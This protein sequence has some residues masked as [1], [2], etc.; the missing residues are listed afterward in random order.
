MV[1]K[2][3]LFTSIALC[4]ILSIK[5]QT[6][7]PDIPELDKPVLKSKD[8]A[9][10]TSVEMAPEFPGGIQNFYNYI[11]KN[12]SYPK[13]DFINKTQGKV[14]VSFIVDFDGRLNYVKVIKSVSPG[15][16]AEA[17]LLIINSP[18]WRPAIQ[19]GRVVRVK[20]TIPITFNLPNSK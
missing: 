20:Y 2:R 17:T 8:S 5:A 11:A 16:D 12:L 9:I 14:I 13:A 1:M 19:N 6:D 3:I 15:I 18:R 7:P 10:F 4:F